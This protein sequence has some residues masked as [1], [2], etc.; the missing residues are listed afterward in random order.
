MREK[1]EDFTGFHAKAQRNLA[2]SRKEMFSNIHISHISKHIK[3]MKCL[4]K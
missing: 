4:L 3:F 1:V 2:Q